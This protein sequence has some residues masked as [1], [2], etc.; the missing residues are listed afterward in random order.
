MKNQNDP[1]LGPGSIYL[2]SVFELHGECRR[3]CHA[4]SKN[5]IRMYVHMYIDICIH[6]Y[7]YI[8][9]CICIYM[10]HDMSSAAASGDAC[11]SP[12][13]YCSSWGSSLPETRLYCLGLPRTIKWWASSLPISRQ[14]SRGELPGITDSV[15]ISSSSVYLS[16]IYTYTYVYIY[17]YMY[18]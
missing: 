12:C 11:S 14:Q 3:P 17:I 9:T 16:C 1:T 18:M 13:T 8:S 5:C 15:L 10:Y 2:A 6:I 4:P 7:V